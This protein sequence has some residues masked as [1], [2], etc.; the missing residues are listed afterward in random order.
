MIL[1]PPEST[2]AALGA[3]ATFSCRGNGKVLWEINGTQVQDASQVQ[4]FSSIYVFVPLPNDSISELI[5]TASTTI[6]AS[7]TIV[8][9]VEPE[10]YNN[11]IAYNSSQVQ[12]FVY[13]KCAW[14]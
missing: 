14:Y 5:V 12:L 9:I 10:H 6:N 7:L 8:C 11:I 3:N 4:M 1:Q 13:G 2:T